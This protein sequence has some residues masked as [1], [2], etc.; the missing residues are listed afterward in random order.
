MYSCGYKQRRCYNSSWICNERN[1]LYTRMC[2]W[3]PCKWSL[4]ERLWL[5]AQNQL[6]AAKS[7][8]GFRR[9]SDARNEAWHTPLKTSLNVFPCLGVI[10]FTQ[11]NVGCFDISMN[12][13]W[14]AF[15][16]Q[17]VQSFCDANGNLATILPRELRPAPHTYQNP[18]RS[19]VESDQNWCSNHAN[20]LNL[21]Q[22]PVNHQNERYINVPSFIWLPWSQ[23][24]RL[25]WGM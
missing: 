20:F 15:C 11:E 2:P 17:V 1:H 7:K 24:S 8:I 9:S 13:W 5:P 25:P 10:P 14:L 21:C 4:T 12:N 3:Y 23:V 6:A 22:K 19:E 18:S 16:M